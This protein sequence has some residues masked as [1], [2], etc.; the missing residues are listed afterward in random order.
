MPQTPRELP[1]LDE[2]SDKLEKESRLSLFE[3]LEERIDP[4]Q[5]DYTNSD[6]HLTATRVIEGAEACK[7][8]GIPVRKHFE[9]DSEDATRINE[10]FSKYLIHLKNSDRHEQQEFWPNITVLVVNL[11]NIKKYTAHRIIRGTDEQDIQE[12]N[13][14]RYA[15]EIMNGNAIAIHIPKKRSRESEK[16]RVY[17]ESVTLNQELELYA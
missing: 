4:S 1:N 6:R 13:S 3:Y 14:Y 11:Y 5:Y 17:L 10:K 9:M 8:L 12:V 15:G 2:V 16:F 7:F